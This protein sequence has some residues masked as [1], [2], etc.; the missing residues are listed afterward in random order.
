[1]S[2]KA[3]SRGNGQGSVY[4]SKDG[5]TWTAQAVVGYRVPTKE[6]GQPIPVKRR[7][8]GFK[9]KAEAMAYLP[10]LK[11]LQPLSPDATL[12]S[13]YDAWEAMYSPRIVPSTMVCYRAAFGHFQK[14][15]PVYI[16]KISAADL[17]QCMDDCPSGKRTNEN[18][19][20]VAGLLWAYAMDCNLVEKNI[21]ENL[22]IGKH[23]TVKRRPL[24]ETEINQI[25]SAI[26]KERYAEYIYCLCY[27]GFRPGE[28][29]ALRKSDFVTVDGIDFL[30]GG[31]KTEAGTDRTVIIPPQI[32]DFVR[33]RLFVPGTD[34]LFPQ[35]VFRRN[36]DELL[37][38]KPMSHA[39]FRE[40]VFKPILTRLGLDATKTPY[41][42]R[43]SYSD[44]LKHA[45]GDDKTKADLMGHTDYAFTRQNY[46]STDLDE[47][48]DVATSME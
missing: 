25:R 1:M 40:D 44:K 20:C 46:Q 37:S 11:T 12:K 29:L 47:L 17:Q 39:Y 27:L 30:I 14:L 18:M 19:K 9:T 3:K 2:P 4:R 34:L 22:Y 8:S 31:G 48:L 32:L 35:Y 45:T 15:H 24:T 23:K 16:R 21:T 42:A 41:S 28:F 13:V 43:H 33:E 36:H 7:K 10:R 38:M 6:G 26:G 5:R